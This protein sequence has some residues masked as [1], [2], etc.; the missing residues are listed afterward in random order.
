MYMSSGRLIL[1]ERASTWFVAGTRIESST[2]W[3]VSV[4]ERMSAREVQAWV[5]YWNAP[6]GDDDDAID[7]RELSREQLRGMFPGQ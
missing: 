2:S 6:P 1:V 5:D 4:V 7:M 3:P